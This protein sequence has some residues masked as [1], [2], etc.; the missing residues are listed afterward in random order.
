MKS[1]VRLFVGIAILTIPVSARADEAS[2]AAK[3]EEMLQLTHVD[4][5]TA[6]MLD[7]V[8]SMVAAQVSK[9]DVPEE[10]R[11]ASAEMQQKMMDLVADRLSWAKA[12]PAYARIYSE[13][14]SEGEIDG[15]LTFYKSPAGQAMLEKMPQLMQ[16]SMAVGQQ[17][18]GDIAPDIERIMSEMKEKN[19][20]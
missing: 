20:K 16:K 14:F 6:Q 19:K 8:K 1:I 10:A 11:K 3:I 15:I 17:L 5:M 7:Q 18:M 9:M 12:K 4:R 2:K 13:T